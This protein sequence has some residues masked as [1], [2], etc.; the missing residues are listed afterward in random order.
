ML[1]L[2]MW[3]SSGSRVQLLSGFALARAQAF[4]FLHRKEMRRSAPCQSQQSDRS[5]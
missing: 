5:P 3:G 2:K 4:L 1:D